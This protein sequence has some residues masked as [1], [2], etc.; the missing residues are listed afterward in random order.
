MLYDDAIRFSFPNMDSAIDAFETLQELGYDPVMEEG[1][2]EHPTLHIHVERSD[3]QSALEIVQTHGG[4]IRDTAEVGNAADGPE[5]NLEGQGLPAH[6]VNEDFS[7]AYMTGLSQA[8]AGDDTGVLAEGY[9][10][11]VYE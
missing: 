4:E 3:V 2:E 7:E 6:L 5:C 1:A 11:S 8:L 9:K 10:D